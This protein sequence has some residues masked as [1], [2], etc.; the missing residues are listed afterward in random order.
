MRY[1]GASGS[2]ALADPGHRFG[3]VKLLWLT[4]HE[5]CAHANLLATQKAICTH[6]IS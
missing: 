3:G 5:S 6:A 4:Y 1:G 2:V